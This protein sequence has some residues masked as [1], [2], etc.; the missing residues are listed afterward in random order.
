MKL[1]DKQKLFSEEYLVDL[2]ATKAAIRAGYNNRTARAIGSENLTKPY[3]K[4]EI[5]R[6][7]DERSKKTEI[8]AEDV[9]RELGGGIH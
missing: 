3:I 4:S 8:T 5:Q 6:L 7:M 2:C 1:T 9:L